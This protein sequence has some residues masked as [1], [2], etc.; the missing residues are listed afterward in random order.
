M[1]SGKSP[2]RNVRTHVD[3]ELYE[4][5]EDGRLPTDN[6][7]VPRKYHDGGSIDWLHEEAVERERLHA[8]K[9]Q[10]GVRGLLLPLLESSRLWFVV[11]MA[12]VGI[13]ITGAWLDVLVK[14]YVLL[15][16]HSRCHCTLF[17]IGLEIYGKDAVHMGSST[18]KSRVV[19]A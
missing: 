4:L 5:T 10:S 13:G 11:I 14:W 1:P 2:P 19:A 6:P 18:I 7:K 16:R 15:V 17:V 9:A 12:G 8:L 3:E